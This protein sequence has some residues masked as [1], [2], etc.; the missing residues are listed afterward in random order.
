MD[1]YNNSDNAM[2]IVEENRARR[3]RQAVLD[4][5]IKERVGGGASG[6]QKG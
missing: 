6:A 4:A 1:D 2:N 5:K 3:L